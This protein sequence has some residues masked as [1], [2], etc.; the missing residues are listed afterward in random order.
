[1]TEISLAP[2]RCTT[3]YSAISVMRAMTSTVTDL[4]STYVAAPVA[5]HLANVSI[6]K[7]TDRIAKSE[8]DHRTRYKVHRLLRP[9]KRAQR[10]AESQVDVP[11]QANARCQRAQRRRRS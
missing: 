3:G 1:M 2:N 9:A 5:L 4:V 7:E 11:Q 6:E 8:R 10:R